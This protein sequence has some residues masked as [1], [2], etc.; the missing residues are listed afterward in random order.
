MS[1]TEFVRTKLIPAGVVGLT[2]D[3]TSDVP[4]FQVVFSFGKTLAGARS[5][6]LVIR[7]TCIKVAL[8]TV[9]CI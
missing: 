3:A 9:A 2:S 8:C 1:L 7:V 5:P 4:Q 6:C